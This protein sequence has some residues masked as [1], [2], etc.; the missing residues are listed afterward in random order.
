VKTMLLK[1]SGMMSGSMITM[2]TWEASRRLGALAPSPAP[3][4]QASLERIAQDKLDHFPG[5]DRGQQVNLR[6]QGSGEK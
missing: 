3:S 6:R 4:H 5:D 2:V 1:K